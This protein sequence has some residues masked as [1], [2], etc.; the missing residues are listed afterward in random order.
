MASRQAKSNAETYENA[1]LTGGG[2][3]NQ[4]RLTFGQK[5]KNHYKRFWWLHLALFIIIGLLIT[6]LL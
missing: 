3:G 1:P 5:V 2:Y 6:L 4:G